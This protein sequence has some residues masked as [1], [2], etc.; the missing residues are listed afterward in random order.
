MVG[1]VMDAKAWGKACNC[2]TEHRQGDDWKSIAKG[3]APKSIARA[4]QGIS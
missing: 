3:Y 2:E 4:E 1:D